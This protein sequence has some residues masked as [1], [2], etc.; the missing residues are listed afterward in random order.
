[1]LYMKSLTESGEWNVIQLDP[2]QYTVEG[3]LHDLFL[4]KGYTDATEEEYLAQTSPA[5]EIPA[6]EPVQ[7]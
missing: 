1:M 2:S 3:L 6:E 4:A 7:E 5:E